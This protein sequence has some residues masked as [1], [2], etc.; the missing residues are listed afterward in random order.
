MNH[1]R[2]RKV[3]SFKLPERLEIVES[4]PRNPVGKIVRRDLR[5]AFAPPSA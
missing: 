1:L 3:A 5:E 2:E 4:I